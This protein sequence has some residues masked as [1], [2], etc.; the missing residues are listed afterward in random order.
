MNVV[1]DVVKKSSADQLQGSSSR[2]PAAFFFYHH[3]SKRHESDDAPEDLQKPAAG[4][5]T[6]IFRFFGCFPFVRPLFDFN[7]WR[8]R[9]D[10]RDYGAR[11]ASIMGFKPWRS[12]GILSK[13]WSGFFATNREW[14]AR[15]FM[16]RWNSASY[17][18]D[19][20]LYPCCHFE[21]TNRERTERNLF[22][23]EISWTGSRRRTFRTFGTQNE[24]IIAN[25]RYYYTAESLHFFATLHPVVC[26]GKCAKT[27]HSSFWKINVVQHSS[28]LKML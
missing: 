10:L 4:K 14:T 18:T 16:I 20:Q 22:F 21:P 12:P 6:L 7:R 24:T 9:P 11:P 23:L 19:L 2:G 1:L 5:Q 26:F 3:V 27:W 13:R 8:S 28:V 17:K 25:V 15:K